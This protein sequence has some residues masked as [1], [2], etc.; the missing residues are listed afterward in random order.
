MRLFVMALT[1]GFMPALFAQTPAASGQ[2]VVPEVQNAIAP[3]PAI[4]PAKNAVVSTAIIPLKTPIL[5]ALD[6]AISSRT[7]VAGSQFQLKVVDDLVINDVIVIPA[8]TPATG[9]IIHAQKSSVFGKAGELLLTIRYIDLHGQKIKMRTFQPYQGKD[10]TNAALGASLAIGMFAAFIRGGEVVMPEK[11]VVQAL[12][13]A[14]TSV[15]L[16]A[17]TAMSSI[18][19]PAVAGAQ[20]I[21]DGSTPLSDSATLPTGDS[22]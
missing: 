19:S 8:G 9:E 14:E 21:N 22:Q 3:A 2:S 6:T 15:D 13:A 20:A 18:P 4:P 7:A 11:T 16:T 10:I 17:N 5:F 1:L 12:V